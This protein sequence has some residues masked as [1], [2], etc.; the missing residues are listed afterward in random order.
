MVLPP[1]R[2]PPPGKAKSVPAALP[3]R[4]NVFLSP[5]AGIGPHPLDSPAQAAVGLKAP[6]MQTGKES[7]RKRKT[8]HKVP[9]GEGSPEPRRCTSSSRD[10]ASSNSGWPTTP[11]SA[12]NGPEWLAQVPKRGP[13]WGQ[14]G[15]AK[16]PRTFSAPPP[17]RWFKGSGPAPS[18]SR[19][20]FEVLMRPG[21]GHFTPRALDKAVAGRP[22]PQTRRRRHGPVPVPAALRVLAPGPGLGP[23]SAS[24]ALRQGLRLLP[25]L[26]PGLLGRR[27]RR[28]P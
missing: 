16:G 7:A 21:R 1:A 26:V 25:C 24:A 6:I 15:A 5:L 11:G 23:A 22:G 12:G 14:P 18:R 10:G 28:Q 9:T 19:A 20:R 17:P 13:R 27:P 8:L 2:P 4:R 3:Q